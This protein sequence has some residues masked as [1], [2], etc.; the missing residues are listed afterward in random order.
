MVVYLAR[1]FKLNLLACAIQ[2][3]FLARTGG[4]VRKVWNDLLEIQNKRIAKGEKPY[5]YN[6]MSAI[7]TDM[8][9]SA[10]YA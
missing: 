7:L 6:E 2:R 3:V 5:T 10:E 1:K 8:K 4:C 9:K